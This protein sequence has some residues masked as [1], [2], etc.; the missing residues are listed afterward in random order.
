MF[1]TCFEM[2]SVG[3]STMQIKVLFFILSYN[4]IINEIF[5]T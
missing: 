2:R 5:Q 3:E 4:Y 1:M